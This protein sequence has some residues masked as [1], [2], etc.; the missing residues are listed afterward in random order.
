MMFA[1]K[2]I[3]HIDRHADQLCE[4]FMQKILRSNNCKELLH[5]VPVEELRQSTREMYRNLA[6]WLLNN[7]EAVS[8]DRYVNLG[9]HRAG[10]GVP[11]SELFWAV[12]ATREHFWEYMERETLLDEPADFWGGVQLLH[13]LDRFFDRALNFVII[14]YES[15]GQEEFARVAAMSAHGEQNTPGNRLEN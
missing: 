2:F 13:S 6:D 1:R 7:T 9:M 3:D 11:F 15:A 12:S 5:K 8:H 4:E 14:G 10:Q